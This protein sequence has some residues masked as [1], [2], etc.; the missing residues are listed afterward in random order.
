MGDES[1]FGPKLCEAFGLDPKDVSRVIIEVAA[2]S[3]RPKVYVELLSDG[4]KLLN[5]CQEVL[6]ADAEIVRAPSTDKEL[7]R[8]EGLVRR[9]GVDLVVCNSTILSLRLRLLA[10][11]EVQT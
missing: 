5:L 7:R 3:I 1:Q 4:E 6:W 8:L 11:E 2:G 10:A 9:L